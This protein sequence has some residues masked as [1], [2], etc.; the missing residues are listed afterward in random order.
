[1]SQQNKPFVIAFVGKI[2]AGK[3]EAA[4]YLASKYGFNRRNFKDALIHEIKQNFPDLISYFSNHYKMSTD[5]LFQIKP[6][7][8]RFLLQNYGTEVRRRDDANYWVVQWKAAVLDFLSKGQNQIVVDDCRFLNEGQAIR[9]YDGIIIRL[10]REGRD[11]SSTHRSET[12]QD[13]IE[14]DKTLVVPDGR[15][16]L[17]FAEVDKLVLHEN[18]PN[19]LPTERQNG[20]TDGGVPTA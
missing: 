8:I 16:D 3:T 19:Q 6:D 18:S 7:P 9:L 1:M 13:Q 12:E 4:K 5:E 10:V 2:G 17:L 20:T 11:E 14:A 15:L